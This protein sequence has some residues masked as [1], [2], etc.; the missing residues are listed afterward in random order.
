MVLAL[1]STVKAWSAPEVS[2]R[3]TGGNLAFYSNENCTN[4][5]NDDGISSLQPGTTI[6]FKV[7]ADVNHTLKGVTADAFTI[8]V[9]IGTG[10]A[11]SRGIRRIPINPTLSVTATATA[12][13]YQFDLVDAKMTI[14]A[15]LPARTPLASVKYLDINGTEQ[16]A[17]NVYPLDGT[18]TEIGN[19]DE[20]RWYVVTSETPAY[21]EGLYLYG[22]VN[23]ILADGATMAFGTAQNRVSYAIYGDGKAVAFYTQ[24]RG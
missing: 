2:T 1:L 19:Q 20:T 8:D 22:D 18:E 17:T 13:V 11:E 16:T 15:E 21:P 3:I 9:S 23:I 5:L 4:W 12:G 10:A 7:F 14:V 6:Y 24:S